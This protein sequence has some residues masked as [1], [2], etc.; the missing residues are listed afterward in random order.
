M[1]KSRDY[2]EYNA[3]CAKC[4]EQGKHLPIETVLF[5]LLQIAGEYDFKT[6]KDEI[7]EKD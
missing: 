1:K 7:K 5:E 3:R 4:I 2:T 6:N